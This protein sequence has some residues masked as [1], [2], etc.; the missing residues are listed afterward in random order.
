MKKTKTPRLLADDE[1]MAE[2]RLAKRQLFERYNYDLIAM[3]RDARAR[4]ATSGH[5]VVSRDKKD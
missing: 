2:V 1:V 4:Q 5:P 3:V